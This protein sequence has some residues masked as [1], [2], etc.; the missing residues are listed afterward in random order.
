MYM[1]CINKWKIK[2]NTIT[3]IIF[4]VFRTQKDMRDENKTKIL[5]AHKKCIFFL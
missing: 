2:I 4:I 1:L 3:I 5:L